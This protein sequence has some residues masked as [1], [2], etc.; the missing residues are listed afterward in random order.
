MK[1]RRR[2][3]RDGYNAIHAPVLEHL[4]SRA[5]LLLG[6]ARVGQ[7]RMVPASIQLGYHYA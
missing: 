2:C 3:D 4:Q 5:F 7:K 1:L 6:L